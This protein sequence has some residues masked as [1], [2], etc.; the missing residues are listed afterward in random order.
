MPAKHSHRVDGRRQRRGTPRPNA[1]FG[2]TAR[3]KRGGAGCGDNAHDNLPDSWV[4]YR[5]LRGRLGETM[6]IRP[7]YLAFLICS[8]KVSI[9]FLVLASGLSPNA[10]F[11][12]S[13]ASELSPAL[14]STCA[15]CIWVGELWSSFTRLWRRQAF[16]LSLFP[17]RKLTHPWV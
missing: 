5:P 9:C 8:C 10:V 2:K 4:T 15:K 17:T 7:P 3:G 1:A 6:R 13:R 12:S 16:A 11:S 14:N